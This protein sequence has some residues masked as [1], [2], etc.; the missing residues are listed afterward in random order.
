MR[1]SKPQMS[2]TCEAVPI[3][4]ATARDIIAANGLATT[5]KVIDKKS[6]DLEIGVDLADRA[7]LLVFEVFSNE[8]LGEG[9]LNSIEDAKRRLVK[10]NAPIIPASG[11]IMVALFGGSDIKNSLEVYDI[12]G[13]DLSKFNAIVGRKLTLA[14]NGFDIELLTEDMDAFCFKFDKHDY[15]AKETKTLKV[16]IKTAGRCFGIVQW[17]RL[18][19]NDTEVV[20]NHPS[21]NAP[22]SHWM[23]CF[24]I[25]EAPIDVEPGQV[26]VVSAMHD[27]NSPWF[28]LETLEQSPS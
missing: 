28:S 20:E 1:L 26:A 9:V 21:S 11:S 18:R 7:D 13:F 14:K 4:A 22:M 5:I 16:P 17:I 15:F 3:I 2:S 10:P 6:T 23:H 24:Y 19:L 27:R 12:C 25:L 8:L